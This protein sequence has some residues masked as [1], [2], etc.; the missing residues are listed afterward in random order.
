MKTT[1]LQDD[2]MS[3]TRPFVHESDDPGAIPADDEPTTSADS[4][5]SGVVATSVAG[6]EPE[7]AAREPE[8]ADAGHAPASAEMVKQSDLDALTHDLVAARE[9]AEAQ[10]DA[11]LRAQAEMENLRKRSAREVENVRKFGVERFVAELLPVKDSL[12]LGLDAARRDG[13]DIVSLRDG[14][15]LVLKM[16]EAALDK[17]DVTEVNPADTVF[18]PEYHQAMST[19]EVEG[20]A[21]GTVVQVV[22]KG[23]VL[24]GRL[25]RPAMVIVAK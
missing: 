11:L 13:A 12:E 18:D 22:Q 20:V 24:S 2:Q 1:G 25:V 23:Y 19:R 16:L 3:G 15:E 5:G 4:A 9:D 21:A 7:V 14:I 17:F 10:H 6:R 8:A